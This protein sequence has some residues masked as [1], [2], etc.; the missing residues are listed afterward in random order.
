MAVD[1]TRRALDILPGS[2]R[3][4]FPSRYLGNSLNEIKE[5]L[6]AASGATKRD[7]QKAKKLLEQIPR[8]MGD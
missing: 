5:M 1:P 2:L 4:E 3:R 6:K 7:L 8:L